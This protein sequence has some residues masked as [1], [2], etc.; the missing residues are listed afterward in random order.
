M[1]YRTE[2]LAI[3]APTLSVTT[4]HIIERYRP[5]IIVGLREFHSLPKQRIRSNIRINKLLFS[6]RQNHVLQKWIKIWLVGMFNTFLKLIN[7]EIKIQP[8]E[9]DTL[10]RVYDDTRVNYIK[11]ITRSLNKELGKAFK[12]YNYHYSWIR[13]EDYYFN[14]HDTESDKDEW[15]SPST[16]F[17]RLI[18]RFASVGKLPTILGI[19]G[20]VITTIFSFVMA[21]FVIL[22]NVLMAKLAS[23]YLILHLISGISKASTTFNKWID[24]I[25]TEVYDRARNEVSDLDSVQLAWT[26]YI[27][28]QI[29]LQIGNGPHSG[30]IGES[31][32][33]LKTMF[34]FKNKTIRIKCFLERLKTF[35]I[36]RISAKMQTQ[37]WKKM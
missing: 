15:E 1:R 11:A 14:D 33:R 18:G 5:L 9:V 23:I 28:E 27:T 21:Y 29:T 20:T 31:I 22:F 10:S 12:R 26:T 32:Y 19:L 6:F 24:S 16:R 7:H 25:T 17:S 34:S 2:K 37:K 13:L 3:E 8:I 35:S 30:F 4:S 36:T